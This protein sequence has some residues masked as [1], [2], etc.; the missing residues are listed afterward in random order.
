VHLQLPDAIHQLNGTVV[1][2]LGARM[3]LPSRHA[4]FATVFL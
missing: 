1:E 3:N 2:I 4:R